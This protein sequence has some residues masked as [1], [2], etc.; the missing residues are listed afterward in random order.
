MKKIGL[1][2][3]IKFYFEGG[4]KIMTIQMFL[5]YRITLGLLEFK[6]VPKVL[7]EAVK[8]EL[9]ALGLDFLAVE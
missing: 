6:N 2:K 7:K 8:K 5:A 3:W 1:F 9:E 4:D